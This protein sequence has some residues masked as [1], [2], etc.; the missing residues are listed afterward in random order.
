MRHWKRPAVFILLIV[1]GLAAYTTAAQTHRVVQVMPDPSVVPDM[2]TR[3]NALR[4]RR[5]LPP[6]RL[7]ARLSIAAQDQAN[8]LVE[9]GI[10][11]HRRP[12]GSRASDR[13]AR[14]GYVGE[15]WCCGENYY[16]SIDATPDMVYNFWV[17]SPPHYANLMHRDFTEMGVG[18]ATDGYRHS[19]VLV[20][21]EPHTSMKV[22]PIDLVLRLF[23]GKRA[24]QPIETAGTETAQ[25]A[26][27]GDIPEP[28]LTVQTESER[29]HIVRP[30]ENLFRI[31]LRYGV[32]HHTLARLNNLRNPDQ[33]YIGQRIRLP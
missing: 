10:R 26:E 22:R 30:G 33:V 3:V 9:T 25:T 12:D 20:F 29:F 7:N 19:Y 15:G 8:W 31:G 1:L 18:M 11:A 6:Y 21:G 32:G 28:Q 4:A 16:M 13:A 2:L 24:G 14:V 17:A 5:G 27:Q 23:A